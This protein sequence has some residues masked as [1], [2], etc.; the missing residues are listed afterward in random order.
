MKIKYTM[1][2]NLW[3]AT[4]AVW[5]ENVLTLNE[6]RVSE[7]EVAGCHWKVVVESRRRDS[8]PPEEKNSIWGQRRSL[9]AQSFCEI[10]FY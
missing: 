10:K 6:K 4:K 1:D 2:H 3:D 8:W 7:D 9:I 5:G